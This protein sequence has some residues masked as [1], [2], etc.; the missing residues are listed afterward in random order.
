MYREINQ[1]LNEQ[2]TPCH[3]NEL[4]L[5]VRDGLLYWSG[6]V[7][8]RFETCKVGGVAP[9]PL[10]SGS[11]VHTVNRMLHILLA[12]R[13]VVI[14]KASLVTL[15][16]ARLR[17]IADGDF[18]SGLQR[19]EVMITPTEYALIHCLTVA[20]WDF[21]LDAGAYLSQATERIII[22]AAKEVL[23]ERLAP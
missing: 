14:V 10:K 19:R 12:V 6:V 16:E 13:K 21:D 18:R 7:S 9:L 22:E 15:G 8:Y 20:I 3:L 5:Q 17:E 2:L 23:K 1:S 11:T 4:S